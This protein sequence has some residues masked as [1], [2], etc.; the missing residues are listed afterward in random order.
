MRKT[1][2]SGP[3]CSKYVIQKYLEKPYLINGRKFD[4]RIWALVDQDMN[5]YF[6]KEWYIRLSS[7]FFSLQDNAIHNQFVH[8]TNNAIQKTSHKYGKL[9]SG[10]I[11][12]CHD[13]LKFLPGA[14]AKSI[15]NKILLRM[16][17]LVKLSLSAVRYKINSNDRKYC[18]EVFGYDFIIDSDFYVW[19]IEVNHNPCLE[20]SNEYL[21]KIIP[22]MLDDTFKL[23]ID[24]IFIPSEKNY[25]PEDAR[26]FDNHVEFPVDG[27]SSDE[28][29]WEHLMNLSP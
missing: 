27:Y 28:N 18:F 21:K 5:L 24:K 17:E 19:L 13:F 22:R 1:S 20:E 14:Q 10:N 6:Y 26:N 7:E 4:I 2:N 16:K 3:K 8:L 9:E 11:M 25:R 15:Y 23:T 29:L 12:S